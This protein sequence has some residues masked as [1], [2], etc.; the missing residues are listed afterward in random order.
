MADDLKA[1]E[2][3]EWYSK[4][5]VVYE[6]LA[7]KVKSIIREILDSKNINYHSITCRAKS[8]ARY[9]EKA[10]GE[11]Y[12]KPLSEIMDMA[13][14]RV[15]TYTNSDAR[16][17]PE[18]VKEA[19]NIYPEHSLDKAEELGVDRVGYRGI[20]YVGDLGK[21]RCKLLENRFFKGRVFEIQIRSMLQHAWA[22]FEHDRNYKFAGVL[23]EEI[24]RRLFIAAGNLE[25]VDREFD[26]LSREIDEYD[27]DIKE[28]IEKGDLSEPINSASL[29]LY[30][31]KRFE[32]LINEGIVEPTLARDHLIIE[33][34]LNMGIDNLETLDRMFPKDYE[35]KARTAYVKGKIN[36]TG[37]L[38]DVLLI[39]D[40]DAYFKKAWNDNWQG[41]RN[42][43]VSLLQSY[44]VDMY[45]YG[46]RY[47]L[48]VSYD[49]T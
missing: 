27:T 36:F 6:A 49:K 41:I 40:A 5:R 34:L 10:S 20:H 35:R 7:E 33:E 47:N 46:K 8:I 29:K 22:E 31:N 28:S 37:I 21:A 17:I 32:S 24:Q 16:E 15:V 18:I 12:K 39:H 43:A 13:G 4:N 45:K 30:M 38:V 19:F 25:S 42:D 2:A 44:G 3:V 14:I 1:K 9:E 23:P 48:N 11:K 26:N